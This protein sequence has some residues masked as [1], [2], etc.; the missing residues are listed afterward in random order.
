MKFEADNVPLSL[1]PAPAG[2]RLLIAPVKISEQSQGGIVIVEQA[3]K[4]ME[5]FRNVAKVLA[6]GEGCYQHPKFQGG[7]SLTERT[8]KPWCQVGDIITYSSYTGMDF[9]IHVDNEPHKL[10]FIN[11]DEVISIITDT[12]VLKVL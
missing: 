6:I 9:Q 7:V 2:W 11:D 4:A 1:L 3:T 12:S 10:K 5:Y 8:P